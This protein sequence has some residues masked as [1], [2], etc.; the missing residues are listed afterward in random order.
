MMD[1]AH[2]NRNAIS[3][4]RAHPGSARPRRGGA[5]RAGVHRDRLV[6]LRLRRRQSRACRIRIRRG[7]PARPFAFA[8]DVAAFGRV[9]VHFTTHNFYQISVVFDAV[10]LGMQSTCSPTPCLLALDRSLLRDPVS[11]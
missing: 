3:S 10:H 1:A 2:R 6:V 7:R 8:H 11:S 5:E 4:G 9:Y